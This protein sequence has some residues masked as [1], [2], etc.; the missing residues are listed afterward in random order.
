MLAVLDVQPRGPVELPPPVAWARWT[1]LAAIVVIT[2]GIL[3]RHFTARR[4]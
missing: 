2:L 3:Q 4:R 1:L